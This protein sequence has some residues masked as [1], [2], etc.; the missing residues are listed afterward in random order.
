MKL[1]PW[2]KLDISE[3]I[4]SSNRLENRSKQLTRC[5]I[6]NSCGTSANIGGRAT[7]FLSDRRNESGSRKDSFVERSASSLCAT[8][9]EGEEGGKTHAPDAQLE[10]GFAA[11]P[12][13][14]SR[15]ADSH[16]LLPDVLTDL[17]TVCQRGAKVMQMLHVL[18]A[19]R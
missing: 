14:R 12:T 10:K 15:H 17:N 13:H 4:D 2:R 1:F 3:R 5:S 8:K 19:P 9:E 16:L 18:D 7:R 6:R 11:Q